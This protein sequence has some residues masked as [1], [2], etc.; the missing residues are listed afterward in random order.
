MSLGQSVERDSPGGVAVYNPL[1]RSCIQSE[2]A[3]SHCL[4]RG[5]TLDSVRN[6]VKIFINLINIGGEWDARSQ[7]CFLS[8]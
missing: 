5:F 1:R 2:A 4:R 8:G 7:N 6:F 3:S